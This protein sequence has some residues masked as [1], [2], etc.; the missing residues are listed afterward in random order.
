MSAE[1]GHVDGIH[2]ISDQE[3]ACEAQEA[4]KLKFGKLSTMRLTW[5]S[6]GHIQTLLNVCMTL[7]MCVGDVQ[8]RLRVFP[9]FVH[10]SL[11]VGTICAFGICALSTVSKR[12]DIEDKS[13]EFS[14]SFT[15][16]VFG[17]R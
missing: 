6:V 1:P 7:R 10:C 13:L 5:H 2:S 3:Y 12:A 16:Q 8:Y 4:V 14:P 11:W 17:E 9:C 15:H